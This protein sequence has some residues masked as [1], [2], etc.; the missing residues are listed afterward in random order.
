MASKSQHGVGTAQARRLR[1]GLISIAVLAALVAG[2]LLAVPGLHGVLDAVG[3]MS[4]GWLAAALI[5]EILSCLGYVV[6]FLRVFERAPV[7]FGSRVALT[8]M[9]FGAAVS[10]GGA[11]SIVVGAWLLRERGMATSAIAERSAVL[12]LLTTAVN[13]LTLAAAGIGAGLGII[14]APDKPLLTIVPGVVSLALLGAF[15][16]LPRLGDRG[17]RAR[18]G[19]RIATALRVT[20]RTIRETRRTLLALDWH[21]LG[22]LAFLW[23]DIA[24]LWA[25]FHAIG[26][27]PPLAVIV[28]AYQIGYLSNVLPI[29]GNIG[30]LEGSFVGMLALY[31]VHATP[32]AA[33]AVV[34]HA[35]ALWIPALWG[36]YAFIRLRRSP[37]EPLEADRPALA[38]RRLR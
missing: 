2:L 12:F 22:A 26:H 34:Y 6:I 7:R 19:G 3:D 23:C 5:F 33:A 30:V 17:A 31:G 14:A 13:G 37:V 4:P 29:P 18:E 38:R 32:A 15:L 1:N 35:I 9:A 28:L 24:V 16:A 27:S 21:V 25:C 10:L 8:E 20:A 36:T 11:G